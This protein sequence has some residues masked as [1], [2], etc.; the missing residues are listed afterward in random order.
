MRN[1]WRNSE[2]NSKEKFPEKFLEGF[3]EI[4]GEDFQIKKILKI[5][6]KIADRDTRR[7]LE[8]ISQ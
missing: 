8:E 7:L 3:L 5:S 2:G 6:A 4:S 1:F